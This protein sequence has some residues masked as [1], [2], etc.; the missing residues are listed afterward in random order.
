MIKKSISI[1]ALLFSAPALSASCAMSDTE[2]FHSVPG[3]ICFGSTNYAEEMAKRQRVEIDSFYIINKDMVFYTASSPMGTAMFFAGSKGF[4]KILG[5][6]PSGDVKSN[7]TGITN[8]IYN[9]LSGDLYFMSDAWAT[10]GAI[11]KLDKKTWMNV[12]EF[13]SMPTQKEVG[14]ITDGNS[15]YLIRSGKYSGHLIVSKHKYR[16]AGGSYDPYFLVTIDGKELKEIGETKESVD[17]F[18]YSNG[19]K[20]RFF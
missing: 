19:S 16:K 12:L 7:I 14:Y 5:E 10:S 9:E 13:S 20:D 11:H 17:Q 15:L 8:V 1:A 3:A 6:I 18:L 2:G 4:V